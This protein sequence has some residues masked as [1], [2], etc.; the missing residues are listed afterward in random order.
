[1][2]TKYY[3]DTCIWIDYF[4][5][6]VDNF[7]PLGD[8]SLKL[9]KKIVIDKDMFI[10]S[11]HLI[12]ELKINYSAEEIDKILSIIPN[13]L[14]LKVKVDDKQSKEAYKIKSIY[15]IPFGDALHIIIAKDNNAILISRDRHILELN[16]CKKPED[17][18]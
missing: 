4:E 15:K 16:I 13:Q 2:V 7:R 8:W 1:M 9:I 14:L 12:D 18:I 17:L 6:R 11:D 3:L 5:N 10:I